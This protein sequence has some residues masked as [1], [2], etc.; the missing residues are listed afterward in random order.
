[1][2][3]CKYDSTIFPREAQLKDS[4]YR[5]FQYKMISS[6]NEPMVEKLNLSKHSYFSGVGFFLP[7][8]PYATY[9]LTGEWKKEKYGWQYHIQSYKEI[10]ETSKRGIISFLTSNLIKGCGKTTAE[11]I[12]TAFGDD[13]LNILDQNIER[14]LEIK[15]I[16]QKNFAKIQN[17]YQAVRGGREIISFLLPFDIKPN[18]ALSVYKTLG[19]QALYKVQKNPYILCDIPGISF[20]TADKIAVTNK[21]G[22]SSKERIRACLLYVLKQNEFTGSIGMSQSDMVAK[23]RKLLVGADIP[24]LDIMNVAKLLIKENLILFVRGMVCAMDIYQAENDLARSIVDLSLCMSNTIIGL[25]QKILEWQKDNAIM[26]APEQKEAVISSLSKGFTVIT[27]GPGTGKTTIS[28]A[29]VDIRQKYGKKKTLCLM[30]PTGKA[31]KR[32]TEATGEDSSTIHSRLQILNPEELPDI[33]DFEPLDAETII[34][35]EVSMLDMW[36]ARFLFRCI[37]Q[38][39][40]VIIVGDINQLPSVGPGAVLKDIIDSGVINVVMLTQIFRQAADNPIVANAYKIRDGVTDLLFDKEKFILLNS[41]DFEQSARYMVNLYAMKVKELGK[42]NVICLSPHHH[43]NTLTST[44]N[45][46]R[47]IQAKINPYTSAANELTYRTI[48]FRVG[49][50]VMQTKNSPTGIANGDVG[51]VLSVKH[52][53]ADSSLTIQFA[54]K[55]VEYEGEDLSQLELAFATTVHKSQGS[56]YKC[57]ILNLLKEH[58]RMLKR[59]IFYTAVTRAKQ[60]CWLISNKEALDQAILSEDTNNRFTLLSEKIKLYYARC[61][62]NNPFLQEKA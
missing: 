4:G 29:I 14:L 27:G 1:M 42:D 5:V 41:Y 40:Q 13:T 31:A 21:I 2:I 7:D 47:Y 49:D 35:D 20:P 60:E 57:V 37:K 3:L 19:D 6:E 30:A 38:G 10:I 17:S 53:G 58:G 22:L 9:E 62:A 16:S 33:N 44:D 26:L 28:K 43:A 45:L 52:D 8:V 23:A 59:N 61:M 46:N 15:G 55:K 50:L 12:Y 32:M 24:T 48:T 18:T 11:R 51:C 25:E 39:C 54:D 36:V 34:I 56:E